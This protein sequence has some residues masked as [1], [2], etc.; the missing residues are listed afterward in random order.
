MPRSSRGSSRTGPAAA[1]SNAARP[2]SIG[3]CTR[4][5]GIHL[6][7]ADIA[8]GCALGYLSFRFPQIEWR[9]THENLAKLADKL[10]ARQSFIDTVP[11]SA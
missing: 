7:L 5:S 1:P 4:C 3:S 10:D 2:G 8:V 9:D 6:S 11:P